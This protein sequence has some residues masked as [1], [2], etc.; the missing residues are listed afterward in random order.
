[1]VVLS[2]WLIY[3]MKRSANFIDFSKERKTIQVTLLVFCIGYS[4]Q[5]TKNF[6]AF[7]YT[8]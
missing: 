1:M 2:F 4:I 7:Y 8:K 3:E 6:I 5:V